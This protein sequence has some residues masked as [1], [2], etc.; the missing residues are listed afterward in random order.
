MASPTNIVTNPNDGAKNQLFTIFVRNWAPVP[1]GTEI[2]QEPLTKDTRK[3][4]L[5]YVPVWAIHSCDI[6][7]FHDGDYED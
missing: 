3:G 4:G 6:W 7:S 1:P 2:A 5:W